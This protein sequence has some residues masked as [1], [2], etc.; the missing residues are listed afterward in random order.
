MQLA[1]IVSRLKS[2]VPSLQN[3]VAV[4][5]SLPAAIQDAKVSHSAWLLAPREKAG[6]NETIGQIKQDVESRFS[7]LVAV[8]NV[9]DATGGRTWLHWTP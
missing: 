2:Q 1:P 7:V 5:A 6:N 4:A 8:R 3:R 9:A